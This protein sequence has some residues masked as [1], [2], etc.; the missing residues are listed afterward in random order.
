ME[1]YLFKFSLHSRYDVNVTPGTTYATNTYVT[2]HYP[3]TYVN[4]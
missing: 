1:Q 2:I 4:T 3:K